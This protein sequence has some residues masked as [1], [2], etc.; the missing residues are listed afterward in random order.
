MSKTI[1]AKSSVERKDAY[2]IVT[3][4]YEEDGQ[5]KVE[6]KA[7]S[8]AGYLHVEKMAEFAKSNPYL[9]SGVKLVPCTLIGDGMVE[10]PYVEGDRLDKAISLAVQEANWEEVWNKTKLLKDIIYHVKGVEAFS[11]TS[12]FEEMFGCHPQLEGMPAAAG[13]NL[14]MVAANIIL[15][16]DIYVLDYEWNFD[17]PVP[18]KYILYR[19]VLLNGTYQSLPEDKKTKIY[20][21][22][23]ITEEDEKL[24]FDME[25]SFQNAISGKSLTDVYPYMASRSLPVNEELLATG[26][27]RCDV[28]QEGQEG[29]LYVGSYHMADTPVIDVVQ[30]GT[31]FIHPT[32]C[33]S[34]IRIEEAYGTRQGNR[35]DITLATGE[36]LAWNGELYYIAPP[37]WRVD[38]QDLERVVVRYK[39][40]RAASMNDNLITLYVHNIRLMQDNSL[41]KKSKLAWICKKLVAKLHR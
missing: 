39:V 7:V 10:F 6:K 12:E 23:E 27:F 11:T 14:D 26:T 34:I 3:R 9:T 20:E 36:E 22:T 24:F 16:E 37:T 31:L 17:F 18:L 1:Y 8:K 13:V 28:Q 2:K 5:K 33:P 29:Y 19:S 30:E 21:L 4:I 41:L 40:T 38:A 32:D 35:V 25:V 15:A